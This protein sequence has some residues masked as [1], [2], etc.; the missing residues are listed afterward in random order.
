VI[1]LRRGGT[2]LLHP[3][4]RARSFSISVIFGTSGTNIGLGWI[5]GGQR[6]WVASRYANLFHSTNSAGLPDYS[7][8]NGPKRGKCT[9]C[10]KNYQM[11]INYNIF[12][13]TRP[14]KMYPKW[15]FWYEKIPSGNP[16][17]QSYVSVG[18]FGTTYLTGGEIHIPKHI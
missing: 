14:T 10:P 11:D 2:E 3:F 16:E 7:L 8:Y 6:C 5:G 1:I 9:Q 4:F 15:D 13:I 18:G 12:S 17:T